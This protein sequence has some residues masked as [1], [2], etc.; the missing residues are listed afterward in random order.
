MKYY[1]L[2]LGV[3]LLL[4]TGIIVNE[5]ARKPSDKF[6]KE[7][8]TRACHNHGCKHIEWNNKTILKMYSANIRWLKHNPLGISY[9]EM[10]VLLYVVLVPLLILLLIW[11]LMRKQNG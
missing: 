3:A 6:E 9:K 2:L 7:Y 10:N 4:L 11:N 5:T 1:T 8:C